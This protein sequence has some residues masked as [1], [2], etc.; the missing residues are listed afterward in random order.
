MLGMALATPDTSTLPGRFK[1]AYG[2]APISP[3]DFKFDFHG[4]LIMP[5][6]VG[7]NHRQHATSTQYKQV[8]HAPPL[9]PDDFD[10]FEHTGVTPQPWAQIGFSYGNSRAVA[11]V[12]IAARTATIAS[13]YVNPPDQLGINQ[14]FITFKPDF[15]KSLD[16]NIDVGAF[17]NRYGALGEYDLG[18]YETPVIARVGGVGETLR[19]NVPLPNDLVFLAEHGFQGQFD[20]V[21]FGVEPAGWNDFSDPNVGSSFAHHA[22]LGL[23]LPR[24]AQVGAHYINA[25]TRDDRAPTQPDGSI[26]VFGADASVQLPPFGRLSVAW[27]RASANHAST[28]SGVIRVLNTFGGPGLMRSYLGPRSEG[29]G[30]ISTFGGQYDVSIGEIVRANDHQP[31]AGYGPDVFISLFG[32]YT[33]VASKQFEYDN[34]NKLK[35]GAEGT[36]SALS[37]LAFSGRYDRVVADTKDASKTFAVITPRLIFRSDYNSQDQV[38]IQYSHWFDGSGVAV[39]SGYPPKEDPALLPDADTFSITGSMW[40]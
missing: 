22:H 5:L 36:Y 12:I 18:R 10:R 37:W 14:A 2:V 7:I 20:R 39:R 27:G 32:M 30:H 4:Y 34:V 1:P 19:I 11:N 21:P 25:F 28:V 24:S 13:G 8:Y 17:A 35:Y 38:T 9:V 40:W 6:R 16:V 33:H 29:T 3:N 23:A 31:F 15:G 26:T